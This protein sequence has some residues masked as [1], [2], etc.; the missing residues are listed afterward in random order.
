M[1]DLWNSERRLWLE[2]VSAYK[3]LMASEC[4]MAFGPMG[5]MGRDDIVESLHQAPRW[6]NVEMVD[7]TQANPAENVAVIAYRA[8]GTRSGAEPY[9]AVCTSTYVRIDGHWLIAQHQQTPVLS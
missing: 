6:S 7:K 1:I 8:Y 4:I 5:V 2:G 3:Q 9:E